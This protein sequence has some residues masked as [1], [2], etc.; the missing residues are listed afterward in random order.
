MYESIHTCIVYVN[1]HGCRFFEQ[2][3]R[4]Q[5]KAVLIGL[6]TVLV[7]GAITPLHEISRNLLRDS[8]SF[9]SRGAD[10]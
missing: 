8:Q 4:K 3:K 2:A 5:E 9:E 7:V 6:C 10:L 1:D